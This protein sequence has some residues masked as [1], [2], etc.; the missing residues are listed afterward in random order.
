MKNKK[1][2]MYVAFFMVVLGGVF[3]Y[4]LP[5]MTVSFMTRASRVGDVDNQTSYVIGE[6]LLCKADGKDECGVDV[7]VADKDGLA[8]QDKKVSLTGADFIRAKSEV[9]DKY[10]QAKFGIV[11]KTEGQYQLTATV[12]GIKLA[13]T[14]TITFKN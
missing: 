10:G 14:V 11:S 2:L 12:D 13:R 5:K 4:A 9:T 7:F 1:G 8:V 6:K 3:Y